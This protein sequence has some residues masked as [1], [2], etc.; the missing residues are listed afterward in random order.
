MVNHIQ[1]WCIIE[2]E[3][4]HLLEKCFCFCCLDEAGMAS[5]GTW[6]VE[7]VH[8][9]SRTEYEWVRHKSAASGS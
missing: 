9:W 5:E 6:L 2:A 3:I 1:V 7:N 8:K 4:I